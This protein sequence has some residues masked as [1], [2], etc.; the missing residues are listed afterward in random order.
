MTKYKTGGWGKFLIEKIEVEKETEKC[1]FIKRTD[2]KG[3]PI[4]DRNN[5][6]SDY[7]NFFDTFEEAKQFLLS[8]S[9]NRINSYKHNLEL[10]KNKYKE[11]LNLQED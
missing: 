8:K 9:Y 5:K 4:L 11:I 3:K 7:Y 1:V 6:R 2:Y 10:E